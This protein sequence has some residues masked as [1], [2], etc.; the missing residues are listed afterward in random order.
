MGMSLSLTVAFL[1]CVAIMGLMTVKWPNSFQ[2]VSL[3]LGTGLGVVDECAEEVRGRIFAGSTLQNIHS[4]KLTRT[5]R[6]APV[7]RYKPV[8][9]PG[10]RTHA[11]IMCIMDCMV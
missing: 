10:R 6:T 3:T 1:Q 7:F 5:L 8:V 4:P 11:A 2:A 9:F